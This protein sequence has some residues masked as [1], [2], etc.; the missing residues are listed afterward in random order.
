MLARRLI[1]R[2][3]IRNGHLIKPVNLEGV[4]RVGDPYEFATRYS[5]A[6]CADE[7][8]Y[9]DA[10]ASLYGRD[11]I[12]E[13]VER[14]TESVFIPITV[15]GGIKSLA[16]ARKT[17]LAGADKI[18]I[19]SAVVRRPELITEV[20][21]ACGSQ[22][23]VLQIDAKKTAKGYEVYID[24]GRQPTGRDAIAWAKDGVAKGAGEILVTSIDQEGTRRGCDTALLERII[25]EVRTPVI[26]SGGVGRP[27][28]VVEAFRA[29]ATGVAVA[30][31]L[32]YRTVS[33]ADFRMAVAQ[34][35]IPIRP[36][37]KAA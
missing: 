1:A 33:M 29:G 2:L 25:G 30:H 26:Y 3:D 37:E 10:V 4:R 19:N 15:G 27:A 14:T 16:D 20:A 12:L 22:A 5:E 18:A 21:N 34:A 6:E 23:M 8:I 35:G 17:L 36:V 31:C 9:L 24:G 7:L 13:L 28:D 32:H 11:G